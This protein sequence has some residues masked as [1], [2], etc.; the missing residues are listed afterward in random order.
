MKEFVVEDINKFLEI[1]DTLD[2]PFKFL[3]IEEA[4]VKDLVS[5]ELKASV[6]MRTTFLAY[7]DISES[8]YHE[9]LVSKL[10]KHG[11]VK[12]TIRQTPITLR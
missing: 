8:E 6:W 12:A 7:E 3:Q 9:K 1:S 4:K 5:Y 11:F 2:T 10:L